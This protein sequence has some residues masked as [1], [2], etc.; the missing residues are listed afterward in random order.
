VP[1][2]ELTHLR[3]QI[4]PLTD[5]LKQASEHASAIMRGKRPSAPDA[6]AVPA[7]AT[8]GGEPV[9]RT[10]AEERLGALLKK[11]ATMVEDTSVDEAAY[12]RLVS[13]IAEA[14]AAVS[15]EQLIGAPHG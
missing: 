4:A 14:Q 15:A 12:R 11:Q 6:I 13:E 7:L 2:H 3:E 10:A 8:N 1:R 5:V 9:V